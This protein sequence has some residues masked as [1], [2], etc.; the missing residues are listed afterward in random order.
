M[1]FMKSSE[2]KESEMGVWRT[3]LPGERDSGP[4]FASDRRMPENGNLPVRR[5]ATIVVAIDFIIITLHYILADDG[6][7]TCN[8]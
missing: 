6:S 2:K 5:V 4:L 1:E 8:A 3:H 7:K